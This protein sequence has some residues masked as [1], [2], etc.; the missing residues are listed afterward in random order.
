MKIFIFVLQEMGRA[1]RFMDDE[2]NLFPQ[3]S[4]TAPSKREMDAAYFEEL[5]QKYATDVLRVSY[6]YLGDRQKA[7]DVCQ[8][9]FVRR[10]GYA[11]V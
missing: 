5:Y 6:F 2:R 9:V 7:E 1:N 3:Q 8:D 4:E 10:S 11:G